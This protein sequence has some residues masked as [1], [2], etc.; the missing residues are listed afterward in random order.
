MKVLS[1]L[2]V[3]FCNTTTFTFLTFLRTVKKHGTE[4]R[5]MCVGAAGAIWRSCHIA[6][7]FGVCVSS[8]CFF[9]PAGSCVACAKFHNFRHRLV[10]PGLLVWQPGLSPSHVSFISRHKQTRLLFP[11]RTSSVGMEHRLL[12]VVTPVAIPYHPLPLRLPYFDL[13]LWDS[14]LHFCIGYTFLQ[15]G[16]TLALVN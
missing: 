14:S 12:C 11:I 4:E 13:F 8:M 1:A 16:S 2:A 15:P 6:E 5:S 3:S 10:L 7:G 9:F